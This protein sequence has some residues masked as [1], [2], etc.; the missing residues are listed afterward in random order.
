MPVCPPSPNLLHIQDVLHLQAIVGVPF[1]ADVHFEDDP[2]LDGLPPWMS[3]SRCT[4][5]GNN[6]NFI[7]FSGTPTAAGTYTVER[8]SGATVFT[9]TIIDPP[10]P[11][12]TST[13][14]SGRKSDPYSY[15]VTATATVGTEAVG[16]SSFTFTISG[17]L[18]T[19]LTV[20]GNGLISG[21]PTTYNEPTGASIVVTATYNYKGAVRSVSAVQTITIQRR[22]P[23]ITSH[24]AGDNVLGDKTLTYTEGSPILTITAD[25]DPSTYSGENLPTGLSVSSTGRLI[26]TVSAEV[27]NTPIVLVATNS[28]G[29]D[30]VSVNLFMFA[31][32]APEVFCDANFKVAPPCD[33]TT[34]VTEAY[35][36][37]LN[38]TRFPIT[39]WSA[40]GLP[41]GLSVVQTA[42]GFYGFIGEI[43]GTVAVPPSGSNPVLIFA[44]NAYG[45]GSGLL[46]LYVSFPAPTVTNT[47][48]VV[49]G[50]VGTAITPFT[51]T[52]TNNPGVIN[53]PLAFTTG[54][55]L[56]AGL[57]IHPTTGVITGT[58]TVQGIYSVSVLV[59]N[60][61]VYPG[62]TAEDPTVAVVLF[63]IYAGA[64]VPTSVSP[65]VSPASGGVNITVTGTGFVAG[66]GAKLLIGSIGNYV[67]AT[68][69]VFVSATSI[70]ATVPAISFTEEVLDVVVINDDGQAGVLSDSFTIVPEGASTVDTLRYTSLYTDENPIYDVTVTGGD[71]LRKKRI[72]GLGTNV[73]VLFYSGLDTAGKKILNVHRRQ[74]GT[75]STRHAAS[76]IVFKGLLS[77]Q[78]SPV[79]YETD[80]SFAHIDCYLR[81]NGKIE[82]HARKLNGLTFTDNTVKAYAAY[83]ATLL[84]E[85]DQIPN[86]DLGTED[87]E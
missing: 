63:Q 32:S 73:E 68:N 46:N 12:I 8:L 79:Y 30:R 38:A 42:D 49:I 31:H 6:N 62:I 86:V 76:D 41:T 14:S 70:T 23:K 34:L 21:T 64:P 16:Q 50:V 33:D 40:T 61:G 10:V 74:M 81:S 3:R 54:S 84:K 2:G 7:R 1:E 78:T 26:G 52:T 82:M 57:S 11:T 20:S 80:G 48:L 83:Q 75:T 67:E 87:C 45:T 71:S 85:L 9:I 69:V 22:V 43:S 59:S 27:I 35:S 37:D 39:A 44:T 29:S 4:V 36:F 56:P 5:V 15:Q 51:I 25:D 66:P 13:P 17:T 58:P 53:S 24:E 19:G 18:P 77:I 28:A 72:F 65:S 55:D 60:D 47:S